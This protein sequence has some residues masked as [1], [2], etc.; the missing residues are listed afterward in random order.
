MNET[1]VLTNKNKKTFLEETME[2][3]P[4]KL[5]PKYINLRTLI[6]ATRL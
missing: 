3:N 2:M 1:R 5:F 6:I 4:N